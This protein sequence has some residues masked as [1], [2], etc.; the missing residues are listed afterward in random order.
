MTGS[1]LRGRQQPGARRAGPRFQAGPGLAAVGAARRGRFRPNAIA[2]VGAH[3]R[4]RWPA[5]ITA[6]GSRF[7][8][9]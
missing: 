6:A 4:P 8:R 7:L 2:A 5:A 1:R 3:R 9:G